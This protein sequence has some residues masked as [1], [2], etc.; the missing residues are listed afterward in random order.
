MSIKDYTT[1]QT[2]VGFMAVRKASVQPTKNGSKFLSL[3]LTDGQTDI[4]AKQWDFTDIPPA[5]N[6]VIKVKATMDQY[7]GQ[8]Q[9]IIQRWKLAEP[10]E[11]DPSQFIGRC[12][13]DI[14]TMMNELCSYINMIQNPDLKTLVNIIVSDNA[15]RFIACP[16]AMKHHHAYIG[17]MLEHTLGVVS[18]SMAMS[19]V[20]INRDLL[21]AGAALHDIGKLWEYDWSGCC[22]QLTNE[23]RLHGHI[24]IGVKVLQSYAEYTEYVGRNIYDALLHVI[25]SHHGRLE[26]GSPIEPVIKEAIIIH[27]ADMLD[28]QL[29]KIQKAETES[30][31]SEWTAKIYG[32]NREFY[33]LRENAV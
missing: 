15:D 16:S 2:F 21:I 24:A 11:A 31:D 17:G 26:W 10:G 12:P 9:L 18:K 8:P 23:G 32:I 30:G 1:G 14:G 29:N 7:Q 5:E 19:P 6:T 13:V 28:V 3:D 22:I 20:E 33:V 25:L 4:P 27:Q